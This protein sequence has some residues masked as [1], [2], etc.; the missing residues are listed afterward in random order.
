LKV[1]LKEN[2]HNKYSGSYA[3]KLKLIN[4]QWVE[5]DT[6]HLF[7]E[8]LNTKPIANITNVGLRIYQNDIEEIV[9]DERIGRSRCDYCS[10]W[11]DT[12]KPCPNCNNETKYM[13][14]FFPGTKRKAKTVKE[15][16]TGMLE[17]I[18]QST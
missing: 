13:K 9:D 2:C 4:G 16:V 8:Q 14:E 10:A 11:D 6:E 18:F 17:D 3:E 7:K 5:I 15:E 1:R 12:G